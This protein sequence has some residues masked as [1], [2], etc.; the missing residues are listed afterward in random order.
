MPHGFFPV[1][2]KKK[3]NQSNGFQSLFVLVCLVHVELF[4][5]VLFPHFLSIFQIIIIRGLGK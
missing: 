1:S 5:F 2:L 3:M 4:F